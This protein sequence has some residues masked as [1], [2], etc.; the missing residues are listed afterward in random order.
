MST[1]SLS[2]ARTTSDVLISSGFLT[3]YMPRANG[4]YVKVYLYL[5]Q[6]LQLGEALSTSAMADIF[7]MPEKDVHRA[8]K[9]W[10]S[11]GLL[12]L[13]YEGKSLCNICLLSPWEQQ[14][15][16]S[17][18]P[19]HTSSSSQEPA[20][21]EQPAAAAAA[22]AVSQNPVN[23]YALTP[24]MIQDAENNEGFRNLLNLVQF[25]FKMT[26]NGIDYEK[27]MWIYFQ[28]KQ[29]FD[30][31][32][33]LVEYCADKPRKGSRMRQLEQLAC[34]CIEQELFTPRDI[35]SH[36]MHAEHCQLVREALGISKKALATTEQQFVHRWFEDFGFDDVLVKE[37]CARTV[38]N[39]E[40][41]RFEYADKILSSWHQE[42][43]H[44]LEQVAALDARFMESRRPY[45][46]KE[47]VQKSRTSNKFNNF[48]QRET[49]FSEME[50]MVFGY[51]D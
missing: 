22:T 35:R 18:Q 37:A 28:M 11:K 46:V 34:S 50:A 45:P 13:T 12:T 4:E 48:E 31:C 39:T 51:K 2:R 33:V 40:A 17:V 24:K 6:A 38:R 32:E 27:L 21:S 25:Y 42:N 9:Y 43:V 16:A 36:L 14:T 1:I 7:E 47:R 23:S 10:E 8:L 3:N 30:A 49:D 26:L 44:T 20:V 29:N 15:D 19:V 5:L 41:G